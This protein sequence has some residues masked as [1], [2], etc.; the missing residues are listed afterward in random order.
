MHTATVGIPLLSCG[1]S[2]WK[3][4]LSIFSTRSIPDFVYADEGGVSGSSEVV[5]GPQCCWYQEVWSGAAAAS[6]H[7]G[8][9]SH[10]TCL[11]TNSN[12]IKLLLQLGPGSRGQRV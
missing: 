1:L 11:H 9:W 3:S 6:E 2:Y 5:S 10:N 8:V 4:A 7:S 12:L